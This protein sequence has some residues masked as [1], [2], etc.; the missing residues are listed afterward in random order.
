MK[1]AAI[2]AGIVL[3]AVAGLWS[4]TPE[5]KA[6]EPKPIAALSWLVG[7]VWTADASKMAPGMKIETR[8]QWSDND[9]YIRFNTH[10]VMDKGTAKTYDG[11][12]F[13]NPAQKSLAMWY[14]DAKNGITEGPVE[15]NGDVTKMSFRGPDFE[16]KEADLRVLVARKTKDDYRWS[17]EEKQGDSSWKEVAALEYLRA[18]EN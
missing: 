11:N 6:G 7:G 8:Y 5:K 1:R 12:F 15:V 9:A 17:V 18:A 13:W 14:M 2:V 16:G 10:F 3:T 4:Q